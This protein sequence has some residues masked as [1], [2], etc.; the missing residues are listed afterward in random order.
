MVPVAQPSGSDTFVQSFARGLSV[1][2]T[3]AAQRARQTLSQ[4]A[5]ASGLARATVRRLLLT[6]VDLGYA[7]TDGDTFWLT[8]RV[9]EL[10]YG[11][12]SALELPEIAQPHLERLS[13][14]VGESSSMSVIDGTDIVYVARVPVTRIMSV[15]M[16][17]GT[18]LPANA[19][20]MGRV[21]MAGR[22]DK[23]AA[24]HM[25]DLRRDGYLIVDQELEPGLRAIAAPIV[26]R[27]GATVAAINIAT[28]AS[29]YSLADLRRH[30]APAVVDTAQGISADVCAT[31]STLT[32]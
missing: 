26:D 24:P 7:A 10:G 32:T 6:L 4:A 21:I 14:Q 23:S 15:T 27:H 17:V 30:I 5:Q 19:T 31:A 12:L 29:A 1:I 2:T 13:H 3:F 22:G 20:A 11:Y 25:S 8:P 28:A 9:L 16:T 18:R